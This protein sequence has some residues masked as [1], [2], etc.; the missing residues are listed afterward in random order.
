MPLISQSCAL[1]GVDALCEP[2]S[3]LG[4]RRGPRGGRAGH[5]LSERPE[6]F[7]TP[8]NRRREVARRRR[9]LQPREGA[10]QKLMIATLFLHLRS[11]RAFPTL[12]E[13]APVLLAIC[14][15]SLFVVCFVGVLGLVCED[16]KLSSHNAKKS[17]FGSYY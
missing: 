9:E 4:R 12:L 8:S 3:D 11:R 7:R 6:S 16:E 2:T 10:P 15:I 13:S 14:R 5:W 1:E 17:F